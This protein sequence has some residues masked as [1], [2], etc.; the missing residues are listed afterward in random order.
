MNKADLRKEILE[1]R[2]NMSENE[3]KALSSRI[4]K[5]LID[6]LNKHL[7]SPVLVCV[8]YPKGNEVDIREFIEYIW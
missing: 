7:K 6:N 2:N 8:Y 1:K 3:V 4:N 5:N